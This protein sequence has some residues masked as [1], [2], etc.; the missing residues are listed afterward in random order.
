[1]TR[2]EAVEFARKRFAAPWYAAGRPHR[3]PYCAVDPS[4]RASPTL[5]VFA[6]EPV[7]ARISD[8]RALVEYC[9]ASGMS[10]VITRSPDAASSTMRASATSVP[11]GTR[12]DL[13]NG[14]VAACRYWFAHQRHE[15]FGTPR[16]PKQHVR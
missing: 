13:I 5:D 1:M 4:R 11:A 12:I 7:A 2:E 14:D 9:A 8:M 3:Y 16:S 6:Q 15:Y 10:A